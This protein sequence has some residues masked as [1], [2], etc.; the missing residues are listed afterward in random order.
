[1][2]WISNWIFKPIYYF[3][4]YP[5]HIFNWTFTIKDMIIVDFFIFIFT[6]FIRFCIRPDE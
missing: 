4:M 1:M 5:I 3:M 6:K 2:Y